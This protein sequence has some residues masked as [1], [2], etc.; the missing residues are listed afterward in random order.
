MSQTKAQLLAPIGIITCPGLDV[1]VGGSSPFQVGS[2]GIIT[3]VSASFSGDV[4]V[5]GTLTYEDVTNIDS[6]GLITARKG[7]NV[8]AGVSTFA[9]NIDANASINVSVDINANGNIVG[10]DA[11]NISGI[12][13]VTATNFYGSGIVT[14]TTLYGDGSNIT[15]LQAGG[16][17]Q[18]TATGSI[19]QDEA[20]I[21]HTD[22]TVKKVNL[23]ITQQNPA[24]GG[25]FF[26]S[27]G[28]DGTQV[29]GAI[30]EAGVNSDGNGYA[31][32]IMVG[33]Y[34]NNSYKLNLSA[35]PQNGTAADF[36]GPYGAST[37]DTG[38][39]IESGTNNIPSGA[40]VNT[41]T[42]RFHFL[43]RPQDS[44]VSLKYLI[45]STDTDGSL[46]STN[47]GTIYNGGTNGKA[48][49]YDEVSNRMIY[50][51]EK[52]TDNKV[53]A[54]T[55]ST[56]PSDMSHSMGTET[57]IAGTAIANSS[58]SCEAVNGKIVFTYKKSS[59]NYTYAKVGTVNGDGTTFTL[60]SEVLISQN[61][62]DDQV[63]TVYSP[64][65]DK[66]VFLYRYNSGLYGRVGSV[67][68]TGASATI[69]SLGTETT[70]SGSDK[71]YFL[72][73]Y[74]K[75]AQKISVIN[76]G[77]NGKLEAATMTISG[78]SWS[79]GTTVGNLSDAGISMYGAESG[80]DGRYFSSKEVTK[81]MLYTH[82]ELNWSSKPGVRLIIN[83][84]SATNLTTVNFLGFSKAAYTNG[85]TA[86]I[87]VVGN[88]TTKSGLTPG[89]KYYV[90]TDGTVATSAG[91]PSVEAGLAISATSLLIR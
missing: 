20:C 13:S 19:A 28:S 8:T 71:Q 89:Q 31:G 1:T 56:S 44:N 6:V 7:I 61:P 34:R 70:T 46:G 49:C 65:D 51:Y 52:V 30:N 17:V 41:K 82:D 90:Q 74:D 80:R 75:T 2:T 81:S 25:L 66:V 32:K 72:A 10:D 67:T 48:I 86:T 24:V 18:L 64:A 37:G 16:S 21:A 33:L 26:F 5:G 14:A 76:N 22:G 63:S 27:G 87:K 58:M 57:D 77:S 38:Q 42:G 59:N 78:N 23:D 53:Y 55:A 3:A 36:L 69:S 60:G 39:T 50:Y 62:V 4:A 29:V 43:Y 35:L 79:L 11:T 73:N 83:A 88:T 84:T 68:G 91:T 85:Q 15:G 9:A 40:A 47:T 12:S 54:K 45:C